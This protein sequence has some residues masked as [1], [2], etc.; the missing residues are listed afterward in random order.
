MPHARCRSRLSR[1]PWQRGGAYECRLVTLNRGCAQHEERGDARATGGHV[2]G[3]GLSSSTKS[4]FTV[5]VWGVGKWWERDRSW[6]L[7]E[8]ADDW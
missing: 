2:C 4:T 7:E 8:D 3:A 5:L 6:L 1:P